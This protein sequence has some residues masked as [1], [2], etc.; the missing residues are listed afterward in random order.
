[1]TVLVNC[2]AY[3]DSCGQPYDRESTV[4][5]HKGISIELG[6]K[7]YTV[8]GKPVNFSRQEAE[9]LY[10]IFTR[11]RI[12]LETLVLQLCPEVQTPKNQLSVLAC[13]IRNKLAKVGYHEQII[14]RIWDWGYQICPAIPQA[15]QPS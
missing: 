5:E 15:P 8:Y 2:A 7:L 10:M 13:R 9:F 1:M 12:S 14:E 11:K 3:C 4:V 6:R